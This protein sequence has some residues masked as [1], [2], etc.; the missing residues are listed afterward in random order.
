MASFLMIRDIRKC[1][2]TQLAG[3]T[4]LCRACFCPFPISPMSYIVFVS[5]RKADTLTHELT[6]FRGTVRIAP[7]DYVERH[8]LRFSRPPHIRCGAI[9]VC[10]SDSLVPCSSWSAYNMDRLAIERR[11]REVSVAAD[12][13]R[14]ELE[15][16][17]APMALE[18]RPRDNG[19]SYKFN[20]T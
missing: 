16:K 11:R 9:S 4:S 3:Y 17:R 19:W 1:T 15:G 7:R 5:R 18:I 13:S 2:R 10:L 12:V 14:A 8:I 6:G 20:P